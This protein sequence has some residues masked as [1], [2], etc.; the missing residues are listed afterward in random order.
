MI[1]IRKAKHND[2]ERIL[3][4]WCEFMDFHEQYDSIYKR[5]KN[6]RSKFLKFLKERISDRNSLVL[7]ASEEETIC[8]YLLA[9]IETKPP[10]FNER[11]HGVIFDLATT[12]KLRRK[13]IGEK[14]FHESVEW[15]NKKKIN[16]VE[17][18][19]AISNPISM[20]FW[21]KMGFKPYSERRYIR[22]SP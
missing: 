18:E 1:T 11:R 12:E 5:S 10:V 22:I 3:D 6:G 9:K 7:V 16:R 14:L 15:F 8:G 20:K 19:V 2:V 21:T 4:L 17:L 13:G